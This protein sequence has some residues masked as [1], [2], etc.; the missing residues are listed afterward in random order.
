MYGYPE[1]F[2]PAEE[3]GFASKTPADMAPV[4]ASTTTS[5]PVTSPS[6]QA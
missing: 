2:I 6:P 5:R 1:Q 3:F 4:T